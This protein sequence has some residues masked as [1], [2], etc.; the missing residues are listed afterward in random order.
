MDSRLTELSTRELIE[1][2]ATSDP[3]PGGG[4]AS[5]L[6]GAMGAALVH[7]VVALTAG[8][9]AA[10]GHEAALALLRRALVGGRGVRLIGLTAINL[11]DS[12]QLTLF[13]AAARTDRLTHSIDA[14]RE[15]F[16][17]RAITR[18]R[19]LTERPSRRF[20]FGERPELPPAEEDA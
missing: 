16:G 8:R 13:D 12:Q 11:T 15:R 18:A 14:V 17:E 6:A 2:L 4:S 1:R 3:I 20:D 5:A 19:L 10:A 9:P 7:M